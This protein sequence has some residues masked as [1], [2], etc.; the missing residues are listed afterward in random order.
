MSAFIVKDGDKA[1]D[2]ARMGVASMSQYVGFC[3]LCDCYRSS[4]T[5]QTARQ[6]SMPYAVCDRH[7]PLDIALWVA[8]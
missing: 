6:H 7:T 1:E 3:A 2:V 5:W 4:R 8:Q